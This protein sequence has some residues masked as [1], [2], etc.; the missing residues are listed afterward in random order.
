MKTSNK[1]LLVLLFVFL[2]A[3]L[4]SNFILK[5]EYKKVKNENH[6]NFKRH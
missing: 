3:T 4:G 2:I 1:L 5:A 6:K